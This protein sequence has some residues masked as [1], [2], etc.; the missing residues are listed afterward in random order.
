[1]ENKEFLVIKNITVENIHTLNGFYTCGLPSLTSYAGFI[2]AIQ[3]DIQ[4]ELKARNLPEEIVESFLLKNFA[5]IIEEFQHIEG[6]EKF[7][8]YLSEQKPKKGEISSPAQ[9][10]RKFGNIKFHLVIEI[11]C[12]NLEIFNKEIKLNELIANKKFCGGHIKE[13]N[14]KLLMASSIKDIIKENKLNGYFLTKEKSR[15]FDKKD[16]ILLNED[17]EK[18][19]HRY[20]MIDDL[21]DSR[22]LIDKDS[23]QVKELLGKPNYKNTNENVWTYEAGTG[24]GFGFV[25]HF[26]EIYYKKNK[27]Q[28]IEHKRIQD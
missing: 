14:Y 21:I 12:F 19:L 10:I 5:I 26:L 25:D 7:T 8:S 6:V 18:R 23:I 9:I 16:W 17:I 15:D 13:F 1:M 20:E 22:V 3:L 28:K 2:H 4:K 24:G 11:E 27:V